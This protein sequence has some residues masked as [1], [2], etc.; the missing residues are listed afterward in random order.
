MEIVFVSNGWSKVRTDTILYWENCCERNC[1]VDKIQTG[2]VDFR[3][4]IG[5]ENVDTQPGW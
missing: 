3:S 2:S 1:I 4:V 5:M